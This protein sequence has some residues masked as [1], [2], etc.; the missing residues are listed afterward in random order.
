MIPWF[1][2]HRRP[3][4]WRREYRPYHVWLSEIMLQQTQME[5]GVSYF[6][7][8]IE[9]F[10]S[11]EHVARASEEEIFKYW[12]GLGYYR[13]ARNLHRAARIMAEHHYGAVPSS[14]EDL[15]AL[16]GVGDYT[17]GAI[18]S[19]AWNNPVPAIDANVERV[20]ARL[21]DWEHDPK[22]RDFHTSVTAML[23]RTMTHFSP[24]DVTQSVME[25]GALCCTPKKPSCPSCP[26]NSHCLA[27]THE[28]VALRP[29]TK[30]KPPPTNHLVA[31]GVLRDIQGRVLV[32]QRPQGEVLGGLWEFPG[33]TLPE[34]S[35]LQEELGKF[36]GTLGLEVKVGEKLCTV[37]HAFTTHRV[38][39][40]GYACTLVG[41]MPQSL[42]EGFIFLVSE[43]IRQR[44]FHGGGRKML[45]NPKVAAQI[46]VSE[47]PR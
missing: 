21:L 36:F 42:P 22:S 3:L 39:L 8:W 17:A 33:I 38:T 13:R 26:L 40:H 35:A 11:I 37:K 20:F 5:R 2:V 27:L 15:L 46:F 30:K 19:I 24:R 7:R 29:K 47:H 18:A 25:F 1:E 44:S 41:K 4:P 45:E 10:P 43:Q 32:H 12:E 6:L 16:P 34:G 14:K 28:T 31:A 23:H 9:R